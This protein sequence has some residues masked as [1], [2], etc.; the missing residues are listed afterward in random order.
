MKKLSFLI[1]ICIATPV[2]A[3]PK[4]QW[5][6]EPTP[7]AVIQ[8]GEISPTGVQSA[9]LV[10][11]GKPIRSLV[12]GQPNGYGSRWWRYKGK[13][14]EFVG[15]GRLVTFRGNQPTRGSNPGYLS[16]T[17]AKKALFIDM[18]SDLYYSNFRREMD[19][20]RAAEGFWQIPTNCDTPG[21]GW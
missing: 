4:C 10:W 8:I 5:V 11:K 16:K 1:L 18:G 3:E 9:E 17:A 2:M 21:R 20:I 6:S 7:E 13:D 12:M 19:L 14:G 15:G